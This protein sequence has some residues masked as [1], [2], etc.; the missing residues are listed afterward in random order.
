MRMNMKKEREDKNMKVRC[1]C[2]TTHSD[3]L[4]FFVYI[5]RIAKFSVEFR[6]KVG[7]WA[8]AYF[9]PVSKCNIIVGK[10]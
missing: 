8:V 10:K 4:P 9:P 1:Y 6:F 2:R 7:E 5:S 3:P